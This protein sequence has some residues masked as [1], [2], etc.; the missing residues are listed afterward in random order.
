MNVLGVGAPAPASLS[1]SALHFRLKVTNILPPSPIYHSRTVEHMVHTQTHSGL[2]FFRAGC[3][4]S[5]SAHLFLSSGRSVRASTMYPLSTKR[6]FGDNNAHTLY[7]P[8][9]S[10]GNSLL[11]VKYAGSSKRLAALSSPHLINQPNDQLAGR[12]TH[13]KSL[14]AHVS[15]SSRGTLKWRGTP[16]SRAGPRSAWRLGGSHA[17][18]VYNM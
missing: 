18:P 13:G 6:A 17:R 2:F 1:S 5:L 15:V 12:G 8:H 10:R 9:H 11:Y 4:V 7:R 14:A 16:S 3:G